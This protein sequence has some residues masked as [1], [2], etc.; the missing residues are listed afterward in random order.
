MKT[1]LG[2]FRNQYL[3]ALL[4]RNG[5]EDQRVVAH[6]KFGFLSNGLTGKGYTP[7]G[8]KYIRGTYSH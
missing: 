7:Y 8:V 5:H 1:C 4:G 6:V 3:E 2:V